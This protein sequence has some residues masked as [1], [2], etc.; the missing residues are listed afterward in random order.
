MTIKPGHS[1]GFLC[2][3]NQEINNTRL[4]ELST[5]GDWVRWGASYLAQQGVFCGHGTDNTFDDALYLVLRRLGLPNDLPGEL[6]HAK[7]LPEERQAVEAWLL[8]R[9]STGRPS[10]YI[11]QHAQFCGLDFYVDDRVLVPRS[12][13]AELIADNF[14]PWFDAKSPQRILDC[15]T[16]S[17]CIGIACAYAFP[18]AEVI[19]SDVSEDALSVA[20]RNI[21]EHGLAD[22]VQ[23]RHA[24]VL[25]GLCE[26][27]FDLIVSNPPYVPEKVVDALPK[28][29]LAEPRLGLAAGDDGLDIAHQILRDAPE[30]LQPDGLLVVEVGDTMH[31]V[32][33]AYPELPLIWPDFERGGHGI[34]LITKADL[35]E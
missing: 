20:Q 9:G 16:G 27:G 34:F 17:G 26:G 22:R 12:P 30:C 25:E 14:S 11:S 18:D 29:Y 3:M 32:A 8:E 35:G 31:A 23:V 7:L 19:L 1:P 10:S 33:D 24:N 21:D 4:Q 28:E 13:I 5:V 6:L 2:A 15:C